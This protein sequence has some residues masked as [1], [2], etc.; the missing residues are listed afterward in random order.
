MNTRELGMIIAWRNRSIVMGVHVK[1][2]KHK[3]KSA[4]GVLCMKDVLY[5]YVDS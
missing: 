2:Y 1:V 5:R 3:L 4:K